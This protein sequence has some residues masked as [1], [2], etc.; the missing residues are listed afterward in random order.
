M[1]TLKD[2]L[3]DRFS[4]LM[5]FYKLKDGSYMAYEKQQTHLPHAKGVARVHH[6]FSDKPDLTNSRLMHAMVT[7]KN[8]ESNKDIARRLN[9]IILKRYELKD[10]FY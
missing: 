1:G 9:R 4:E 6:L 3:V 8:Q 10:L 5:G 2:K 7:Y